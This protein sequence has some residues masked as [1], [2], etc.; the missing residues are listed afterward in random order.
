MNKKDAKKVLDEFSLVGL[1][2]W[3]TAEKK[4]FNL[5]PKAF[6]KMIKHLIKISFSR[7]I[8]F[9]EC[10]SMSAVLTILES[11]EKPLDEKEML[12]YSNILV[13]IFQMEF[14][15]QPDPRIQ[16]IATMLENR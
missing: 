14:S 13:D 16:Q 12:L 7:E 5:A 11:F 9:E 2:E 8:S 4:E 1:I 3:K 6:D 10:F 15:K